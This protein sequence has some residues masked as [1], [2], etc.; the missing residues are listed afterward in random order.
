MA[1]R[2]VL[3][4][5]YGKLSPTLKVIVDSNKN[6]H[7]CKRKAD[8]KAGYDIMEV[9]PIFFNQLEGYHICESCREI[10]GDEITLGLMNYREEDNEQ[11]STDSETDGD[12]R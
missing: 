3:Y 4:Y 5:K 1:V 7:I 6:L 12:C 2:Q 8:E 10:L 9:S 11:S